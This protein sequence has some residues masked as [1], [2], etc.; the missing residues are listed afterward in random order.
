MTVPVLA[1]DGQQPKS[2]KKLRPKSNRTV[3]DGGSPV[4]AV[5]KS[6]DVMT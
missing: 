5:S 1:E 2:K 4:A 3:D 6:D